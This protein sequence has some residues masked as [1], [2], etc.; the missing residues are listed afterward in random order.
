M[1]IVT[2]L[3]VDTAGIPASVYPQLLDVGAHERRRVYWQ[4]TVV[5]FATSVRCNPGVTHLFYTNDEAPAYWEGT[6]YRAF[7]LKL[8]VQIRPLAFEEFC[9]PPAFGTE[10]RN[11][12][13]KLEVLRELARPEAEAGSILLD[14]DCVWTRP[15]P[16]LLELLR[17]PDTLLLLDAEPD[18]GPD[19]K[20]H[21]LSR[22][23]IGHLYRQLDPA[24]PVAVP[25][26]Y[27]GEL[28][29]GSR[30][31]LAEVAA[32][33]QAFWTMVL[34][35]YPTA[36]PRFAS[37]R[38]LFDGDEYLTS[39][40]YNRLVRPG[41]DASPFIRRIWTSYRKTDVRATDIQLPI[42]HLP[43]EKNQ[44]LPILCRRVLDLHSAFWHT[45]PTEL[46]AY[47]G[48]FLG[49]PRPLWHPQRLLILARKLPR[50]LVVLRRLL[51]PQPRLTLSPG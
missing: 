20:V 33:L 17:Q 28:L 10:F 44:G 21:G 15:V 31:R 6:D 13:Y 38:S 42:W 16:A 45:A 34:R 2:S 35:D 19:T 51:S 27:G 7:L 1:A 36:A 12:F 29:G 40:V 9:P 14:S 11:A 23:D 25:R 49:V 24:Y 5:F 37:G 32:E 43:N 50:V 30:Q 3:C 18:T 8:G 22:R 46:A 26:H 4:C 47:L 39:F 41:T 48:R